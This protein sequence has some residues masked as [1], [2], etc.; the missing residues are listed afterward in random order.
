MA[1]ID[2]ASAYGAPG[3]GTQILLV[4]TLRWRLFRNSL[5]TWR[6][7]LEALSLVLV[8]TLLGFVAIAVGFG[9]GAA[10]YFLLRQGKPEWMGLLFWF[11]FLFWQFVPLFALA[12]TA[13]F[14]FS[15]L[16]RFPL[17]F[18][19]FF[20]LSLVYGLFEPIGV[21]SLFWLLSIAVGIELARPG[22]V[23]GIL[24]A[25]ALFA[26]V[27]ILLSRAIFS[28]LERWLAQRRTREL[29]AVVLLLGVMSAQLA[30]PMANHW[31][32]QAMPL[33][34]RVEP[35][36]NALP[37]GLVGK[38]VTGAVRGHALR[39]AMRTV[40]LALYGL[41]FAWLLGIRLLAQFRGEDLGESRAPVVARAAPTARAGW[42]LGGLSPPVAAVL[43]KE[44]RYL[45]RSGPMM[46][47]L[48]TPLVMVAYFGF[49]VGGEHFAPFGG[50]R[51]RAPGLVLPTGVGVVVLVLTNMIYNSLGFDGPGVRLLLVAPVRFRDVMLGKNLAQGVVALVESLAVWTAVSLLATPPASGVVLG[52]FAALLFA[53]LANFAAG[54]I[55]SLYF[56]RRLEFGAFRGQR[57]AGITVFASLV[58]Q[59]FVLGLAGLIFFLMRLGQYRWLALLVFV[60]LASAATKLYLWALD[61]CNQIALA[62]REVLTDE[63]CRGQ[64]D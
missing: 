25:F 32:K 38:T 17:R 56:P 42:K 52:T 35:V 61:R 8:G 57:N 16:L 24:P 3:A 44:L 18:S 2:A 59:G 64:D 12:T 15:N 13:Q 29:L 47:S 20:L 31:G 4:M 11:V 10:A 26:A 40:A 45:F 23:A 54:N 39:I 55:L 46:L 19:S 60:V 53:L 6:G 14:D 28:W 43:E 63:L 33:A 51:G 41:G 37:P 50:L 62:R 34:R 30:G 7:R 9:L 21:V 1:E 5:R 58:I 36:S 48:L 49:A 27:N 22:I